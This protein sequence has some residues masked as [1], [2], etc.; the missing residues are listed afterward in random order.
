MPLDPETGAPVETSLLPPGFSD[1]T[2]GEWILRGA[3]ND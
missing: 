1:R 3:P 2:L